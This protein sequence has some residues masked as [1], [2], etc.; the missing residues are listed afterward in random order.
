VKKRFHRVLATLALGALAAGLPGCGGG[1]DGGGPTGPSTPTRSVVTQQNWNAAFGDVLA[2]DLTVTGTGTG[3]MDAT[4]NWRSPSNDIDI[5]ATTTSCSPGSFVADACD[6][7][8]SAT[9]TTA[10][11]ERISFSATGG[12]SYRIWIVNFGPRADSG[13]IEVGLTR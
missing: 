12:T 4:V 2:V 11:P 6:L 7:L 9:T 10:K 3:T 8:A 5:A 13:T 1:G